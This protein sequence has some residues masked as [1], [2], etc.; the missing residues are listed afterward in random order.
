MPHNNSKPRAVGYCRTSGEKQRDN[1]SIPRQKSDIEKFI[2][3]NGWKFIR[4]YVDESISGSKV[5]GRDNFKQMMKD[6]ANGQFDIIVLY[7]ISRFARDGSDIIRESYFLKNNFGIHVID[8]KGFDNRKPRNALLNFVFAGV[9]EDERLRI[10]D[11]TI[12]AR[13]HNAKKGLP[14]APKPPFGRAFKRSSKNNGKWYLT[15]D[16][17]KLRELLKRYVNGESLR[18]LAKEYGFLSG[19]TITRKVRESQLSAGTYVA[20][21]HSPEIGIEDLEV[22]IPDFPAVISPELEKRV[23]ERMEHNKKCNKQTKRKYLLSGFVTCDHCGKSLNGQTKNGVYYRHNN[24]YADGSKKCLYYRSIRADILESHVLDYLYNFFFDKPAY[25]KAVKSALPSNDD[26][27]AI[28]KDISMASKEVEKINREVANLVNAIAKG[29]DVALLVDK[30]SE[31]KARKQA[32]EN[33]LGELNQTLV[34]MPDPEVI[35]EQALLLRARMLIDHT[36]KDWRKLPY[37]DIRQFL[38]FLFSDNPKKNGYGVFVAKKAS[39]WYISFEGCVDF[40]LGIITDK[41]TSREFQAEIEKINADT[42]R[43]FE[44]GISQANKAYEQNINEM[45]LR[46]TELKP[47]TDYLYSGC[48]DFA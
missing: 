33:R 23:I 28:E 12:I 43:I 41:A 4:H 45:G 34:A 25:E 38:H 3:N 21:F 35:E 42:K 1:T 11:R 10:M 16:G 24:F 40:P 31:L 6:A 32:L 26:R 2:A 47:K 48:T 13:I 7:D 15:E 8:T 39:K 19:Q 20:K 29:A 22:Q 44:E 17:K 36:V 37:E 46:T 27:Q 14:W 9:A 18:H 30:Q 5:A